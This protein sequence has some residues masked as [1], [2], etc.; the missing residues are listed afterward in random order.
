MDDFIKNLQN[1]FNN[2]MKVTPPSSP[3]PEPTP[4]EDKDKD[5]EPT[6][7]DD[8]F[9]VVPPHDQETPEGSD[10]DDMRYAS[11]D[12]GTE[13]DAIN[14]S[15]KV[16]YACSGVLLFQMLLRDY[17]VFIPSVMTMIGVGGGYLTTNPH[18]FI[19]GYGKMR[20][21]IDHGLE[22]ITDL[23]KSEEKGP[24]VAP[25]SVEENIMMLQFKPDKPD[26]TDTETETT[27]E[28][29]SD[30]DDDEGPLTW[31]LDSVLEYGILFMITR[32]NRKGTLNIRFKTGQTR[33]II[34]NA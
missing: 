19:N 31:T 17:G 28:A 2:D 6:T 22:F 23:Y 16:M 3:T 25:E 32:E 18:V 15:I 11:S 27:A 12:D 26:N 8:N 29:D 14:A 1:A 9:E 33:T 7:S 21:K 24:N 20:Q 10:E 4:V 34:L 5:K 30:S 13:W